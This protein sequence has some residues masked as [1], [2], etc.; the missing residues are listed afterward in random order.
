MRRVVVW[1]RLVGGEYEQSTMINMY[2]VM[3][4]I[5]LLPKKVKHTLL[6]TAL[7]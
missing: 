3:A 1:E 4:I 5:C 6:H 2:N 7:L